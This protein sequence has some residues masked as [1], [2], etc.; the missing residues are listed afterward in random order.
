MRNLLLTALLLLGCG[1][2][3]PD[4]P[5]CVPQVQP[6]GDSIDYG[7]GSSAQASWREP[8]YAL[9]QAAGTPLYFIGFGSFA[10]DLNTFAVDPY[11]EG[12]PGIDALNLNNVLARMETFNPHI[13]IYA[14][15][16][17]DLASNVGNQSP[18]VVAQ[19]I[20]DG[21][22]IAWGYRINDD[23]EI[24]LCTVLKR[25]DDDDTKVVALNAML[26]AKVAS[27]SFA[28]H[29]TLIDM[30]KAVQ[31]PVVGQGMFD[32]VHPN[33]EGYTDM[34]NT[35]WIG[36]LKNVVHKVAFSPSCMN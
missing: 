25:L 17:N 22:D 3:E 34:A 29:V 10:G 27:K 23:L 21:L 35:M 14:A 20:S 30:Y 5:T 16:T 6:F 4:E 1:V 9:A 28:A 15:G 8:E 36:G 11:N 12:W 32:K 26:A 7:V 33:D 24:V 2:P 18:E 13:V 31:R 19:R